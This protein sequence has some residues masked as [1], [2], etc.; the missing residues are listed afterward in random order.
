MPQFSTWLLSNLGQQSHS[1]VASAS[2]IRRF[3]G[4]GK[5]GVSTEAAAK[6][7]KVGERVPTDGITFK[8]VEQQPDG[9]CTR[10]LDLS[11]G[12]LFAPRRTVVLVSI[13]GA[14]TPVCTGQHLPG[15]V[16][17]A[18]ELRQ[19]GADAIV[20]TAVNDA[21]VMGAWL[22]S[23][24]ALGIVQCAADWNGDFVRRLGL[25]A[26]F[27]GRGLGLRGQRFAMVV[28]D[29]IVRYLGID[30]EELQESSAEAVLQQLQALKKQS[31]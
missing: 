17:R 14:F 29:G 28:Q 6:I 25:T 23:L 20:C 1:S 18:P 8:T 5:R 3:S 12:Q 13:P 27:G 22:K 11:A 24:G 4:V 31:Q 19:R 7:I 2:F 21:F 16:Q 26:D 9:T 10:P 30:G 15:F